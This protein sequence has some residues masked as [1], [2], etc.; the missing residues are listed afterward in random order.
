MERLL[1]KARTLDVFI[2]QQV[3]VTDSKDTY[4]M[5]WKTMKHWTKMQ[6]ITT[7]NYPETES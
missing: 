4:K 1:P 7:S 6:K 2:K 5:L 3:G